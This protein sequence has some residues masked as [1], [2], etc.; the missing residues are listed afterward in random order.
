VRDTNVFIV[1]VL[2]MVLMHP[3]KSW[4]ISWI[5]KSLKV[6]ENQFGSGKCRKLKLKVLESIG[7]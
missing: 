1:I 7:K 4:I 6:L 2:F 5:L 3:V